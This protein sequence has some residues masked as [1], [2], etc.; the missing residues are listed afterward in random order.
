MILATTSVS[1]FK[2]AVILYFFQ[3]I[4]SFYLNFCAID[5]HK[6]SVKRYNV[7]SGFSIQLYLNLCAIDAHK[8][9]I[10]ECFVWI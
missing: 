5:A 9:S 8:I 2:A 10:K 6:I 7:L 3:G 1:T 4:Y